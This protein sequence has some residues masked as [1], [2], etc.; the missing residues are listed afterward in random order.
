MSDLIPVSQLIEYFDNDG[1][2]LKTQ[3]QIS[4]DFAKF[5][6]FFPE[7]FENIPYSKT[8]IEELIKENISDIIKQGETRL[9]QLMY[10]ID[11]PEKEFLHLSIQSDFLDLLTEKILRREAYKVF[12]RQYFT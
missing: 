12:L 4:K 3:Q 7:K 5:N 10:T 8:D 9:L 6:L 2:V 11:L 1:F